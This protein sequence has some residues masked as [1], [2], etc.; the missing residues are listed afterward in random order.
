MR[1]FR[2]IFFTST[3]LFISLISFAQDINKKILNN[4]TKEEILIGLCTRHG[5]QSGQYAEWF[6]REYDYYYY[7]L[8]KTTLDSMKGKTDSIFVTIVLGTWCSDSREQ[9]PRFTCLIDYLKMDENFITIYA[10]DRNK[11]TMSNE[12]EGLNI[13]RVPTIIFYDRKKNELGRII[14]TPLVTLE[15][16][17]LAILRQ[18]LYNIKTDGKK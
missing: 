2:K 15:K 8:D 11:K 16:D 7:L 9:Y 5:F 17:M 10:V 4:S 18:Y 1:A 13:L 12:T 6:S 14:E 3:I